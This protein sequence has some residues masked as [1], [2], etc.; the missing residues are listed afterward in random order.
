MLLDN[1]GFKIS[2]F[3]GEEQTVTNKFP[4][5]LKVYNIQQESRVPLA[6][7]SYT[8]TFEPVNQLPQSGSIQVTYP[9]Q[10][11]LTEGASTACTVQ[12]KS[13]ASKSACKIDAKASTITIQGLFANEAAP[14]SG[15]ITITLDKVQNA[16][17]NKP[18]NGFVI[19]TYADESQT[20]I[21]DKL[22]DFILT[23]L[24]ECEYPCRTC[25]ATNRKSCVECWQNFDDPSYLMFY[26]DGTASCR[27]FCDPGHTTNGN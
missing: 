5:Q 20:Y 17:N 24:F 4:A 2:D 12:T 1:A 23:P 9:S 26:P 15:P 25:S 6:I 18:G 21:I 8:I 14:Y 27:S 3:K 7:T 19:Q 13:Q 10:I 11:S 16:L 22:N